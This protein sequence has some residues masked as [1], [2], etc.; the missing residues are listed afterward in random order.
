MASVLNL[1]KVL[2]QTSIYLIGDVM[3]RAVGFL[4]IPLYTRYLTPAD[5]GT[6][7]LVE[8]FVVIAGI[9]FG[10]AVVSDS[11][12]RIYHEYS[13]EEDRGSVVA[14]AIFTA[15]ILGF[16]VVAVA[17]VASGQM[18]LM[19]FGATKYRWI[20]R[21]A[22][23]ALLF[24]SVTEIALVYQQ[25]RQRAVFFVAFSIAQLVAGAALNVYFIAVARQG[26]LGFILSKLVVTSISAAVLLTLVFRETGYR[27]RWESARRMVGFGGPLMLSS[28][29]IFIIH[30]SDRFFLNHFTSLAAVGIYA[31]AYKLGFLVTYLVGQPFGSVWNVSL[32]AHVSEERWKEKFARIGACL[33]FFLALVAT[34]LAVFAD[35][36]LTIM[37]S[38]P[39]APAALLVPMIAFGYA[40]RETGDFFRGLLFINKRVFVFGRITLGCA[41]LNLALNWVLIRSHGAAGSAW[42]TLLTWLAYMTACWILAWREHRVPLSPVPLARLCALGGALYYAS[43][44]F[45]GLHIVGQLAADSLLM[46]LMVAYGWKA[47][48]LNF[49]TDTAIAVG[50]EGGATAPVRE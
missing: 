38:R 32:Y 9:C 10:L 8:L 43:T 1:K 13:S 42:A 21:S 44:F 3:R 7:E 16:V 26:V 27:F 15:V 36:T 24:S 17:M 2:R 4:M 18:S 33:T 6:I 30:F 46:V 34:G 28:A 47:G 20:I 11:M 12:V 50:I 49:N 35:G 14:S 48:Y 45:H 40:F 25:V 19:V 29:S 22:F 39:Y 31:L 41:A 37:A 5:Y 23:I